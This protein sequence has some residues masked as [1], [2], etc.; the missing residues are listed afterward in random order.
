[1][2]CFLRVYIQAPNKAF[3]ELVSNSYDALAKK[4]SVYIPP[5]ITIKN[6]KI[7]VCDNGFSMDS[8]GLR[9]LWK[10][11]SNHK[12]EKYENSPRPQIG[13]F[14]IGKLATY[15]LANKL[16][17]ICKSRGQYLAVT[18]DYLK[19]D[20]H[21]E[22]LKQIILEERKLT[23][24]EVK[25]I[26]E[27]LVIE[28][29]Q[30]LLNFNLWSKN[31]ED[32]WTFVIMSDL[33]QKAKEIREGRLKWVLRTALPLNP[34]FELY[35]NGAILEP[36]KQ[37]LQPI[38][39]WEIGKED[40]I[41]EKYEDY[42]IT[43]F[44][45]KPA[46]NLRSLKNVYGK[47]N[48][49]RDSLVTGKSEKLG[50]SHGIFL[51]VRGRLINTDDP[52]LGMDAFTHGV[53]NRTRIIIHAD[54]LD[55]YITSTRESIKESEAFSQL[56][57]YL[58][59]KFN[60]E[61]RPY[62]FKIEEEEQKKKRASYKVQSTAASLSRR[63]LLVVARKYFNDEISNPLLIDLPKDLSPDEQANFIQKLE[64]DLTSEKGIIEDVSWEVMEPES[65]LAKLD[66]VSRV[67]KVNVMHPFFANFSEE[68]KTT[69]PFQLIAITE[70]LTEAHL[71][72][73]GIDEDMIRKIMWR[74]DQILRELT[75]SDRPNAPAVATMI[76]DS[77]ADSTGLENAVY[78]A[79]NTLGFE[80]TKIGGKGKPDGKATAV[81]GYKGDKVK[82]EYS[83]VYDA[84]SS[85]KERIASATAKI[86]TLV[87]HRK[88][89]NANYSVVIA[90]DFAGANDSDSA[91][92]KESKEHKVNLIRA[93]DLCMLV[94]LSA[95]KQ[96][97]LL[98]LR[99]LFETCH[100]V[101]ETSGWI[102][103]IKEKEVNKLPIKPL[104]ETIFKLQKED[105]EPPI[106]AAIRRE[107]DSLKC[108]SIE[109]IKTLIQSLETLVPGFISLEG[110]IV[111]LQAK[112]DKILKA[113]HQV[114]TVDIPQEFREA[115]LKAFE[116]D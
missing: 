22:K 95:S 79:F 61:V 4:V 62:F 53:F 21:S 111:S 10:I 116:L 83:L 71:I 65:F 100:T 108:I 73:L 115:Y 97:G 104:L 48:L 34:D 55:E 25:S 90:K 86:S 31:A 29:G 85:S 92:S 47:I 109:Q 64:D 6:A 43:D 24:K 114:T 113:I 94:L 112:P 77:L 87:R 37:E 45:N 19:I 41:A 33:K 23:L 2:S 91:I 99:E 66:L 44:N 1:M 52:L 46:I 89:Y 63:P 27:P 60:N 28:N 84:K 81:L 5:D 88:D 56:Q 9:L 18:M 102:D 7:W 75:F 96:I 58:K 36:S 110:D 106:I 105:T 68:L 12:R 8:D 72:E 3:E 42:E 93:R 59:R 98:E 78:N 76:K 39:T 15:V 13:K 16:T 35:Y 70:I 50:R 69:L 67:A 32:G 82:A 103:K 51:M 57:E 80:T 26:L 30:Y 107:H 38:K 101:D 14:G 49:Y 54:G 17:Y 11:G 40:Q 20:K 74:R